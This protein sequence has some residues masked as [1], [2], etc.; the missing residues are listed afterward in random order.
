MPNW[1]LKV[2]HF[3][4][5]TNLTDAQ[6][7]QHATPALPTA[8]SEPVILQFPA[9]TEPE[10]IILQFPANRRW[11]N[12]PHDLEE[13]QPLPV[14]EIIPFD[15]HAESSDPPAED[16]PPESPLAARWRVRLGMRMLVAAIEAREHER[17][18]RGG[19]EGI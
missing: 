11:V 13:D 17:L 12:L 2:L 4:G 5:L 7:K 16:K 15:P 14:P 6:V 19:G 9:I 3:I 18:Q 1:L 8:G 10:P